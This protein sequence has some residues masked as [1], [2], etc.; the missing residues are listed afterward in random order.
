MMN[1]QQKNKFFIVTIDTEGDNL[2]EYRLGDRITTKNADFIPRFQTLC[3]RF[4]FKP[5]YLT[6][7]EM[8]EDPKFIEFA[9]SE[10][11]NGTCEIG[12]HPHAWNN[13]PLFELSPGKAGYGLPYLIE[14][15]E[16]IMRQKFAFLHERL[17]GAF[18]TNIVSH[19]S[20]RWA[21]NDS[22]FSLLK[23]F[24]IKIDCSVTPHVSWKN[25]AGFTENSGGTDYK[26]YSE[27]A[28]FVEGSGIMELPVS[29]RKLHV[30]QKVSGNSV[31]A[32]VSR[33]KSFVKGNI[34]WLRPDGKN[35]DSMLS[36]VDYI[37]KSDSTYL[38][39]MLHSSE[40]MPGGSPTF[41][42]PES[43]ETLYEHLNL[44]FEKISLSFQGISLDGFH[45]QYTARHGTI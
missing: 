13:P 40:L 41:K 23:E 10:L 17:S 39:F 42:T 30:F 21:M 27:E 20:G 35:L 28:F 22:Y 44:L 3:N 4:G 14:Y 11:K 31:K 37:N 7:F 9:K 38:E 32:H 1:S 18:N 2:W 5:V 43:I 34:V 45:S 33:F 19:R 25:S 29:I 24:G 16:D 26:N 8:V 12:I 6:N 36:L 15:P